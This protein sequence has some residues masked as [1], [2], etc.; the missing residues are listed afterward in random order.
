MS[1]R[2]LHSVD[3]PPPDVDDSGGDG[4]DGDGELLILEISIMDTGDRHVEAK[5]YLDA[6]DPPDVIAGAL[7]AQMRGV[8]TQLDRRE[9]TV[10]F[11]RRLLN[12][13]GP[14]GA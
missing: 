13:Q 7:L 14:A 6:D 5:V 2:H 12:E 8:L 9:L 4:G 1:D 3:T 10:A 11:E